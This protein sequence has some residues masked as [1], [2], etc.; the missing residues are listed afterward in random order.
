M[1]QKLFAAIGR[2]YTFLMSLVVAAILGV[3]T[4]GFW[5]FYQ[6]T[7][8]Q[9]QFISEGKLLSVRIQQAEHQQRSWRDML[10]NT[11]YLTFAYR[12][13]TYNTRFVSDTTYVGEGDR[14][15][16]L[17]H[18]AY[19]A[20]RQPRSAIHF[21]QSTRKSRL[22]GW[23]TIRAF[24][25]ENRLLLLCII[26]SAA[27]FFF[28]SGVIVTLIPIPFLQGIARFALVV[29]LAIG[30][31]FFAYD[32]YQYFHY[33]QHLKTSGR[34]VTVRVLDTDRRSLGR[35]GSRRTHWYNYEATI[36]YQQQE[37]VIAISQ[38]DFETL[39][40][41]D[42]L[43]AYYDESVNDFMSVTYGPDYWLI[44]VPTFFGLL[45]ILFLRAGFVSQQQNQRR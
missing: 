29:A 32:T 40:P 17:Y 25:D 7:R 21:D 10:S 39:K 34:E 43:Q 18:P 38:A 16:L 33:Y 44:L 11:A 37:R 14:V 5:G 35:G 8:L 20:F 9:N 45:T 31:V 15:Q 3:T 6:E 23:T 28:I 1:L 30:T 13:K 12:G 24:S 41:S 2:L 27:S 36:R 19:D 26:L 42:T 4:W 22:I